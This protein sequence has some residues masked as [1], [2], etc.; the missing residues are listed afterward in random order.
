M[1]N[2]RERD[3][4]ADRLGYDHGF[5][6]SFPPEESGLSSGLSLPLVLRLIC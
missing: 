2:L 6:A 5:V 3:G 4:V 1:D